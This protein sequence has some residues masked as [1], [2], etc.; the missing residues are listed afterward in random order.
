LNL[1][2]D[3]GKALDIARVISGSDSIGLQS[4]E[5]SIRGTMNEADSP[6]ALELF[7]TL[8]SL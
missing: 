6:N 7:A 1:L 5:Y 3:T 2:G 4:G 8:D